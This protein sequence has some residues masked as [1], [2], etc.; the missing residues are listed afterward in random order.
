MT[1]Q[2]EPFWHQLCAAPSLKEKLR[3]WKE[4]TG[5]SEEEA[6]ELIDEF[7]IYHDLLH[8]FMVYVAAKVATTE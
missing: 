3:V 7:L 5:K 6:L 4:N 1:A 2:F 8:R